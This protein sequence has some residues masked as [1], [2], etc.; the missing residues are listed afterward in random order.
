M[1]YNYTKLNTGEDKL[2]NVITKLEEYFI[3]NNI[4]LDYQGYRKYLEFFSASK[5]F[6]GTHY[7]ISLLLNRCQIAFDDTNFTGA[8]MV[9]DDNNNKLTLHY[10]LNTWGPGGYCRTSNYEKEI[11]F[12]YE[13][14]NVHLQKLKTDSGSFYNRLNARQKSFMS[15]KF[16]M[17]VLNS[18]EDVQLYNDDSYYLSKKGEVCCKFK[19]FIFYLEQHDKDIM[20]IK[21]LRTNNCYRYHLIDEN[22][23][24]ARMFKRVQ[25]E[26]LKNFF[27]GYQFDLNFLKIIIN[28]L[29]RPI[30]NFS[31]TEERLSKIAEVIDYFLETIEQSNI[32][33][34]SEMIEEKI[35]EEELSKYTIEQIEN[36]LTK[37]KCKAKRQ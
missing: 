12:D 34:I 14:E 11:I 8:L 15:E 24:F 31:F 25:E 5:E 18:T 7:N 1:S 3:K 23:E 30:F 33:V 29:A 10:T 17:K 20:I 32:C 35:L 37:I 9:Q 16:E 2:L 36:V 21:N 6:N 26:S 28:N 27:E 13:L 4:T 22:L 19:E